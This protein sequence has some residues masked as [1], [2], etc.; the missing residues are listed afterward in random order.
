METTKSSLQPTFS[1][2]FERQG[3]YRIFITDPIINRSNGKYLGMIGFESTQTFFSNY[4]NV[5]H[6]GSQFLVVYD[7]NGT[8]LANGA[9][10]SFI[11]QNFFNNYTQHFINS[12]KI[13]NNLTLSLLDGKAGEAVNN[14]GNGESKPTTQSPI[15]VQGIPRYFVQV[16]QPTTEIYSQISA[17]LFS[18]RVKMFLLFTSTI[19]AVG[20]LTNISC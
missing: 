15:I 8:M 18:E 5:E 2:G 11:G 3:V 10:K 16:V 6:I 12:N 14:Y 13:L 19:A 20:I 7:G 4:G 1:S 9:S 17:V